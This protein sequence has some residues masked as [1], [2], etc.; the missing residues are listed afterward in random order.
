EKDPHLSASIAN[1][2]ILDR[3]PDRDRLLARMRQAVLAVPRLHQRVVPA[4]GRLAPPEWRDD[5]E[6][7]LDYHVRWMAV[8]APGDL[9]TMLDLA[10]SLIG[11][12][13]DRTRPLWE[14]VVIEGLEGGR[15]VMLQKLHHSI[16]DGEGGIRMS[17]QFIDLERDAAQPIA[18]PKPPP[19]PIDQNL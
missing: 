7:D 18:L 8:P 12:S 19:E 6:F 17:E 14:F 15:A 11:Q 5:P 2:T 1:V 16:T 3:A 9:R 4:L 10:A 13:F